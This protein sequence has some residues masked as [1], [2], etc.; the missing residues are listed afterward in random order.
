MQVSH[1]H[2]RVS[3]AKTRCSNGQNSTGAEFPKNGQMNVT[4]AHTATQSNYI[5]WPQVSKV[6]LVHAGAHAKMDASTDYPTFS[7][8]KLLPYGTAR[9]LVCT[10][11]GRS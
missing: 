3:I 4:S 11:L 2:V 10:M 7:H 1:Q 5:A 6:V 9:M 8:A